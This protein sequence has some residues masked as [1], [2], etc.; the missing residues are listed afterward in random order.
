MKKIILSVIAITVLLSSCKEK[1]T[2]AFLPNVS[3]KSGE[4]VLVIENK[5][6]NSNVGEEFRKTKAAL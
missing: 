4:V 3:G 6:W 2:S 5:L 1:N